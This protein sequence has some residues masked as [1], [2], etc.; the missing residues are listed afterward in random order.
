MSIAFAS[1]AESPAGGVCIPARFMFR[2]FIAR[3]S[4][5]HWALMGCPLAVDFGFLDA[6]EKHKNSSA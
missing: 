6:T 4:A 5:G 2:L 3:L 1:S